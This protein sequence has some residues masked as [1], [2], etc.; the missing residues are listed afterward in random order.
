LFVIL[1]GP[2]KTK[3]SKENGESPRKI[4]NTKEMAKHRGNGKTLSKMALY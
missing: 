2:S 3:N 1:S 4:E